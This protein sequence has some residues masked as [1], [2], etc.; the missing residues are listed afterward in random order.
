MTE[1]AQSLATVI[2]KLKLEGGYNGVEVPYVTPL[3]STDWT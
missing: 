3:T 1:D 2:V